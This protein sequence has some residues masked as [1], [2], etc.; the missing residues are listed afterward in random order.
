MMFQTIWERY[1]FKEILK[2]FSLFLFS[3]FFLYALLDYSTH[4]QDFTRDSAIQFSDILIYYTHQFIKRASLL[5]PLGLM[6]A[7][8]KV[9]SSLNQSRE[10][11][12]LQTAGLK[13]NTLLK[14]FLIFA[15]AASLFNYASAEFFLPSS[16]NYADDFH[17]SHFR[18]SFRGYRKEPMHVLHLKDQSRLIYQTYN[19]EKDL[20]FDVIWLISPE[21]IWRM[22]YLKA[23]PK[24]PVG[25][26][27]DHLKRR[28][29]GLM[30]KAASFENYRFEALKWR[31]EMTQKGH[32]PIENK[33]LSD[34]VSLFYKKG[35]SS[36]AK[37]EILT[38]FL[39]KSVTPLLP[40]LAV[41]AVAP[42]CVQ[43]S[44][45]TPLFFIY[46][47]ALFGFLSIF[48]LLNAGVI[49]GENQVL[50]PLVAILLP[51]C[52]IASLFGWNFAKMR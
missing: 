50:H 28:Q 18:H 11:V 44:R 1:F 31:Q 2:I 42:F 43:Y 39:F 10:L 45:K 26:F 16:L 21:E 40:L 52:C 34:L 30:E 12:A 19:S 36:Y 6:V 46:A 33:S 49:L 47:A 4:M 8:I 35:V 24:D 7:S 29:D 13:L 51:F 41:I 25:Y 20:F 9:L 32:V 17:R 15:A 14:P 5:I 27:V 3:F 37:P 22:K 23:D 48:A 38:Q